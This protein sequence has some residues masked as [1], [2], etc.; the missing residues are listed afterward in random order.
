MDF[1]FEKIKSISEDNILS[2]KS[3]KLFNL[4]IQNW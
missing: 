2:V 3:I 1:I 4:K